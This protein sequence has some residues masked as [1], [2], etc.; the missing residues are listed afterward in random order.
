[1]LTVKAVNMAS[2][3]NSKREDYKVIISDCLIKELPRHPVLHLVCGYQS[4]KRH[5]TARTQAVREVLCQMNTGRLTSYLCRA[6]RL[7]LC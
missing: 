4:V 1:M 3:Q 5:L 7:K 2:L 6:V